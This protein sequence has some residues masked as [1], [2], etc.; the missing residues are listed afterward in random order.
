MS[1][2]NKIEK[3]KAMILENLK[4][5]PI[6]TIAY[7]KVG[8]SRATFYRWQEEDE[9]FRECC[10]KAEQ[11]GVEN[12]NDMTEAQLLQMTKERHWPSISLWLKSNHSRFMSKERLE[13]HRKRQNRKG[14][15]ERQKLLVKQALKLMS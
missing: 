7:Q 6:K 10:I 3:E 15:T 5:I 9:E 4:K 13:M 2:T 1:T 12:M 8:I 11:E 14:L